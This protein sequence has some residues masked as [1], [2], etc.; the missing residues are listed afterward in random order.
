MCVSVCRGGNWQLL[1]CVGECK[2]YFGVNFWSVG[3]GSIHTTSPTHTAKPTQ[4][5]SVICHLFYRS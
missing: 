1:L 5:K 2:D 4:Q 3:T